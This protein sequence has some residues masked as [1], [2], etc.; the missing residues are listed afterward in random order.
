[1]DERWW[2]QDIQAYEDI[3]EIREITQKQTA[4]RQQQDIHPPEGVCVCVCAREYFIN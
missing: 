4:Q 2:Y 3:P 1:V